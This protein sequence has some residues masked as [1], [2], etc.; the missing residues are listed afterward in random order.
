MED[1]YR[2]EIIGEK[3]LI[4][5]D[6]PDRHDIPSL[7]DIKILKP[8]EIDF[9]NYD[10]DHHDLIL[11]DYI[12]DTD[13]NNDKQGYE[14]AGAIR[15]RSQTIPIYLFSSKPLSSK[16]YKQLEVYSKQNF[17]GFI[18]L[19]NLDE[20]IYADADAYNKI[21]R[22][23]P[24]SF[25]DVINLLGTPDVASERLCRAIPPE[26][27]NKSSP[28]SVRILDFSKWIKT[29]LLQRPGFIHKSNYLAAHLGLKGSSFNRIKNDF[30]TAKYTGIFAKPT[31]ELWWVDK[32]DQIVYSN[33]KVRGL[34]IVSI[35]RL[36]EKIYKLSDPSMEKCQV[37]GKKYTET[38]ALE[39]KTKPD[40]YCAVHSACA[41]DDPNQRKSMFFDSPKVFSRSKKG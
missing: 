14:V 34:G 29:D 8:S 17:D 2:G 32:I 16:I 19:D 33:P 20:K 4:I 24:S 9:K 31:N 11:L 40:N 5:D 36:I 22:A 1:R 18:Y 39:E 35:P 30:Q 26:F 12:L 13:D 25:T 37:C 38:L 3:I 21:K 7:P 6:E 15:D 28:L 27:Y 23:P 41:R 10:F